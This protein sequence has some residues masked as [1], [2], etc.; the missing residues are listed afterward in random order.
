MNPAEFARKWAR[1]TRNERAAAHEHF[2]NL[3]EMLGAPTPNDDPDGEYYAF[4]KG[5][6]KLGGEDGFAD[7]WKRGY[8]AWEYKGKK[9]DLAVAYKQLN[10]YRE[11]LENPPLLVVCDLNRFEVHTNFTNTRSQTL[12]FTLED[13]RTNP[14]E[15]LRILRAVMTHPDDLRPDTPSR[16]EMTA[17]AA[18]KFAETARQ[19]QERDLDPERVAHFLD[20][21][22]FCLFAEDVGLLPDR[23]LTRLSDFRTAERPSDFSEMLADLF[24]AMRSGGHF[25]SDR[26]DWFNGGLFDDVDVIPLRDP[27]IKRVWDASRLNWARIEPAIFGTL[28]ERGL[29]PGKRALLGAHYTDRAA[30]QR[31]VDA[32]V[33]APLRRE[34]EAVQADIAGLAD[35][36]GVVSLARFDAYLARLRRA[37]VLDPACG[38]GNFLY[39]ALNALKNLEREAI[40]WATEHLARPDET[41]QIGPE[42][43]RG[44]EINPYAAELARVTVWIGDLQWMH[45]HGYPID[46]RPILGR[47]DAIECR[48]A[49]LDV[50]D[51][52]APREAEWPAAE[53]I[54]GNPPFLGG[55]LLRRSIGDDAYVDALFR[56]YEGR[57]PPE[58]D[59]VTYWFEKARAMIAAGRATR[60]GLLGTQGIR[61][62]A[63]R[64][65]LERIKSSGDIF[66]A[67]P[68]EPWVLDGANVHVSFVC[69]DGGSEPERHLGGVAVPS[70]NANLTAGTNLTTARRLAENT[71]IAF[72]GDTKGGPFEIPDDTAQRL[73]D[74]PNPDGRSNSEVV[75]PWA[76]GLD[77]TRRPR[78]MWIIDFGLGMS[79]EQAALYE[80]PFQYV[81]MN[82]EPE[83]R[84]NRRAAYAARWWLHVEPRSGMRAALAG[85]SRYLATPTLAKHRLFV[86]LS[87][88]M[89]PDHQIIVIARDD[90]YT[91]GV[92]HSRV[93]EC[94]ALA[95]GTQLETRPRYTPTTCFETFPF[96]PATDQLRAAIAEAACELDRLR[97][98]WLDPEG[99]SEVRKRART[100]T[101]LYNGRPQWLV[102]AH[103][104]L[105]A[106]VLAAYGWPAD[107]S[108]PEI[109][110]RLLALNL[111][112]E[113]A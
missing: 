14:A 41:P 107:L 45:N 99:W 19:L 85:L 65:V 7:V 89:V 75:R 52:S 57:V 80:A 35:G 73:L 70:I 69:F 5:A 67:M 32:V 36:D 38:S 101:N 39:V 112:R 53:F 16:D 58:A 4:E 61:G 11:D 34:F 66:M 60:A 46:R 27:E 21:V 26:I 82:V 22:I 20:R 59:F 91:F 33:A 96:P 17:A 95:M 2:I 83:R 50:A 12:D 54:V 49:L 42:A 18:A 113:P 102:D 103:A 71:G 28:F 74:A 84:S 10:D 40:V 44:I 31:L 72:M 88:A 87:A 56:V 90:D 63:N 100:L 6:R 105:D 106:A 15:P 9:K 3:C 47:L 62:G 79:R 77:I 55:K 43:V 108:N 86:W 76:N 92:L 1:S 51:P 93:H 48:D 97:R 111:E 29:D 78:R 64:R 23:L 25:G 68:D 8:F 110:E 109:L 81:A 98:G 30:I 94:W 24:A 37:T 13:L 104:R